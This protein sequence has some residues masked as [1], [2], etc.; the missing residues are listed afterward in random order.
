M[1][2]VI[3]TTTDLS[4]YGSGDSVKISGSDCCWV[5]IGEAPA[6]LTV[7]DVKVVGEGCSVL[8]GS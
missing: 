4:N 3:T 2:R 7:R 6:D 5:V 8:M 1:G